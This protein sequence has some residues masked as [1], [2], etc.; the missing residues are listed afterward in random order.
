MS[1]SFDAVVIGGGPAGSA[2]ARLLALWGHSVLVLA[3]APDAARGAAESI[4][5][6]TRKLLATIGALES[7]EAAGF[8]RTTGNTVWWGA[9]SR[10]ARRAM[11]LAIRSTG[12]S[13]I[14]SCW[15]APPTQGQS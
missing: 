6:S 4:P 3:R 7:I 14:A 2:I 10:S 1:A 9:S 5:P 13:S 15:P 11:R 12:P 8:L